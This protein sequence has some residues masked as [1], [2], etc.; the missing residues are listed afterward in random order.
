M[1]LFCQK[2]CYR[3]LKCF[4]FACFLLCMLFPGCRTD[5]K[6]S[7]VSSGYVLKCGNLL[8][9]VSEF[10][11]ELEC[12]K[13]AYPYDINSDLKKYKDLVLDLAAQLSQELVLRAAA[14]EDGIS[15]TEKEIDAA[16]KE[17]KKDFPGDSF[18]KMLIENAVSYPVWKKRLGI[19]LLINRFIEKNLRNKIEI[20]P[21]DIEKY[22][23]LHKKTGEFHKKY[24]VQ[25]D[26]KE[27]GRQRGRTQ[28]K[29]DQ[30][31]SDIEEKK[32]LNHLRLQKAEKKYP[33][34]IDAL[35]K[36]FPVEINKKELGIF[37]RSKE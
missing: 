27:N 32:L 9:S 17:V 22:Y 2:Q 21:E 5:N 16:A 28:K 26:G 35:N 4:I 15:V 34:W 33:A 31:K 25:H 6:A 1:N 19:R 7:S 10:S 36:K 30:E 23:Q 8:I 13:S 12:E 18:Q 24:V 11:E 37:L 3:P 20:T 14:A 29:S